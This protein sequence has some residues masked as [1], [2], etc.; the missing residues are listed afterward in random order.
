MDFHRIK[1]QI[2]ACTGTIVFSLFVLAL[3]CVPSLSWAVFDVPSDRRIT[4]NA[5]LDP[6]GGIPHYTNVTC[7]GLDPTGATNN[8][9]QINACIA[10][11]SAGTAVYIPAGVYLINGNINMKSG[12]ALRGAK[13]SAP[14]FLPTADVSATT[15]NM[16][17][18]YIYFYGGSKGTNWSPGAGLGTN[19][20]SGYT[21]GSTSLALSSVSGYSVNDFIS[22]FQD[23]DPSIISTY[24]CSYCGEDN[25]NYHTKQQYAKITGIVGNTITIDRPVYY[26]TPNAAAPQ[27]RKQTMGISSAGIENIRLKGNGGNPHIIFMTFAVNCWVKGVETYNT[28]GISGNDHMQITFSHQCEV[29]DNYIH[30]GAGND[31]GAN[32]GISIMF[33]NSNHK[34]ENNIVRDTRHSISFAGGGSGCA[35]LYNYTTDNWESVPGSPTVPNTNLS[36]DIMSHGAHPHM[37]LFEGNYTTNTSADYYHGSASHNTFF[38]NYFAGKRNTPSYS[39]GVWG[40]DIMNYS[41]YYNLVGNVIGQTTWSPGSVLGN[42]NCSPSEPTAYRFGCT[43][44][45]GSYSDTLSYST[46]IKHA[47][48]DFITDGVAY[49][50]GG[51]DHTLMSS[52]YY[53]AAPSFL[54]GYHWP[55]IGP[56]LNPLVGSL[57]AKDR[58]EGNSV[59][60]K[61]PSAPVNL[62]VQ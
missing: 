13:T 24:Q 10:A 27:V 44:S 43:G 56:D 40:I 28:G 21:K 3:T 46:T 53:D 34:I 16:G 39:W 8:V 25:G 48:Y 57:P 11:A 55:P 62:K 50:D 36:E 18:N 26:V 30:H 14:P 19:I 47:N 20:T 29:R 58:Y 2:T 1:K 33:W 45:P 52:M 41:R 31:S 37:N 9:S 32:Y 51:S 7:T 5:G 22:I 6:V 59:S 35:V 4:W 61:L 54:A 23:D 15:F 38:R 42:G 60:V 12:V 49:W 17:S